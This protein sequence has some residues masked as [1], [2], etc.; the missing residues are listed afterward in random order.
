M[1]ISQLT[2][3]YYQVNDMMYNVLIL[4]LKIKA[5]KLQIIEV[6]NLTR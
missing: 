1:I 5:V 3:C 6:S 2:I 4:L